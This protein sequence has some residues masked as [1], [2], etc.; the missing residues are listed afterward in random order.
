MEDAPVSYLDPAVLSMPNYTPP[1]TPPAILYPPTGNCDVSI[2]QLIQS[3]LICILIAKFENKNTNL[4][5]CLATHLNLFVFMYICM[6]N[7]LK[8]GNTYQTL[9]HF[10]KFLTFAC[11]SA[12]I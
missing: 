9:S 12:I 2:N 6:L 5:L 1:G 3:H 11:L 8:Y 4:A 10:L 7:Q